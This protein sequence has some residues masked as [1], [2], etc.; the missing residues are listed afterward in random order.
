M[1]V[2]DEM[3]DNVREKMKEIIKADLPITKT[4]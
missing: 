1:K 3:I 4:V 2:S